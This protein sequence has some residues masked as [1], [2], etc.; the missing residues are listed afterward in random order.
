MD[1]YEALYT[2]RAMRKLKKDPI[3][4][5]VQMKILDAAIRAPSGGNAQGWRFLIVD[6]PAV[7]QR[8]PAKVTHRRKRWRCRRGEHQVG[9][10]VGRM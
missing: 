10:L 8:K 4:T 5:S 6:D 3:P 2:T 1:A 9:K 7:K